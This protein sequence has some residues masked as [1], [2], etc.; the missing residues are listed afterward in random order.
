MHGV[1]VIGDRVR[2][3]RQGRGMSA[4]ELARHAGVSKSYL[5][6]LENGN[7]PEPGALPLA[8]IAEALGTTLDYLVRGDGERPLV[9]VRVTTRHPEDY[10]L[11]N[12]LDGTRWVIFDGKW[13]RRT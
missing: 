2:A 1:A 5:S 7:H 11:I 9:E 3:E 13:K 10:E 4:A 6:T 12:H 8:R